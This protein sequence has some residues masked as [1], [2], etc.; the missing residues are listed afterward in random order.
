MSSCNCQPG[1][2]IG[3]LVDQSGKFNIS[4]TVRVIF[5]RLRNGAALN[6]ITV[7]TNNPTLL[8]TWTTLLDAT[9][10][11]KAQITP[12]YG[13]G[14]IE[15]GDVRSFGGGNE[16]PLGI[17]I[18][19]G[20]DF[21]QFSG[22]FLRPQP[23]VMLPIKDLLRCEDALA[24]WF[25]NDCG[26]IFGLTDSHSSPTLFLPIPIYAGIL[27]DRNN[28]GREAADFNAMQFALAEGWDDYLTS[29]TPADFDAVNE[30][31]NTTS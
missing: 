30:L 3:D 27:L 6:S 11:T 7:A 8:A 21:S 17:P 12:M 18:P 5:T 22:N 31:A 25:I 13:G 29:Y 15:P 9:D 16:T 4:Q 10:A 2:A 19:L 20:S 28:P 1:A 24:V 23:E 26:D 14:T